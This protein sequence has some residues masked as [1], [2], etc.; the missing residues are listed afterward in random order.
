MTEE[1][2]SAPMLRGARGR[3]PADIESVVEVLQRISQLVTDVPEI[4]ELDVNPLVAQPDGV[5][6]ID[7]RATL[8]ADESAQ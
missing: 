5:V 7:F 3:E 2:Q 8:D 4:R 6:A 1:I